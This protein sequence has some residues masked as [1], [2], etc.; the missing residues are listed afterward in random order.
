M[1]LLDLLFLAAGKPDKR[2]SRSGDG[3][4]YRLSGSLKTLARLF[5]LVAVVLDGLA[6]L[7]KVALGCL[8]FA[9]DA[10]RFVGIAL[11]L[12]FTNGDLSLRLEYC[13]SSRSVSVAPLRFFS[14]SV[15]SAALYASSLVFVS[16]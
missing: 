2:G 8:G 13:A 4:G 10:L 11:K 14:S 12:V 15:A 6:E 1:R 7:V 5:Q 16:P 9:P 3:A